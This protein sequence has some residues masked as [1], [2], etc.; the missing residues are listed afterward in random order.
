MSNKESPEDGVLIADKRSA[1]KG[2]RQ[3]G[4]TKFSEGKYQSGSS[5]RE[6][7]AVS[8]SRALDSSHGEYVFSC[9]LFLYG[10][11]FYFSNLNGWL[12]LLQFSA[13]R[14]YFYL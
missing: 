5:E 7:T 13:S 9:F 6:N 3:K 8:E 12:M 14:C 10:D 4:S 11:L 1:R 2:R